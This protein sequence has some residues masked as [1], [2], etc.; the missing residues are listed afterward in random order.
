MMPRDSRALL[1]ARIRTPPEGDFRARKGVVAFGGPSGFGRSALPGG[2]VKPAA[3]G[4]LVER[5]PQ[6]FSLPV[7]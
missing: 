5:Q 7:G 2:R 4:L 6:V 3:F 1:P